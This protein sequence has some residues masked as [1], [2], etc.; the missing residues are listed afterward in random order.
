MKFEKHRK[1]ESIKDKAILNCKSF[2]YKKY[3]NVPTKLKLLCIECQRAGP[4][5]SISC[6]KIIS[7]FL[8]QNFIA[9][10]CRR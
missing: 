3:S 9:G 10:G 4:L 2:L 6:L 1:I 5:D 7:K 8:S